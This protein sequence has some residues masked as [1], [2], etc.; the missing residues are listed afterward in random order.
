MNVLGFSAFVHDSAAA[1]VK[2]GQ[3]IAAAE[4]ERFNREKH[5]SH[6]PKQAIYYCLGEAGLD[7]N[8][9]DAIAFYFDLSPNFFKAAGSGLK[10]SLLWM[11]NH[12]VFL[13]NA[14]FQAKRNPST[15]FRN[16]NYL[17]SL[18]K[19]GEIV[20]RELMLKRQDRP[21]LIGVPHHLAHIGGSYQISGFEDAS[22]LIADQR[23]EWTTTTLAEGRDNQL[24]IFETIPLP[25]SLG[26]LYGAITAFLGFQALCDE[27]K[28]MGLSSYGQPRYRQAFNRFLDITPKGLFKLNLNYID[29]A[30]ANWMERYPKALIQELGLPR[31]SDSELDERHSDI[32]KSLQC[33]LEETLLSLCGYLEQRSSTDKLCLGGGIGLN[34][35]ANGRIVSAMPSWC[36]VYVPPAPGDA[37]AALGAAVRVASHANGNA[38]IELSTPYLGPAYSNEDCRKALDNAGFSFTQN[39]NVSETTAKLLNEGNIIGWYQGRMEF[40][41]RA[42]G[43]RSI[44]ADPRKVGTRDKVNILKGRE[45]WRPLAPSVLAHKANEWFVEPGESPYMSFTKTVRSEKVDQIAACVHVDGTARFQTVRR[46]SNPRY[47]KLLSDFERLTGVPCVLN[48]SFNCR[49]EPI[50]CTPQDAIKSFNKMGL[51]YLIMGD[52]VVAK[53]TKGGVDEYSKRKDS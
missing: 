33:R 34:S 38:R 47:W 27:G 22:I 53:R 1:V 43:N 24:N 12:T 29:F 41:P 9:L 21:T 51:D 17:S 36:Q 13:K 19:W 8:E 11:I 40:G 5:T 26:S 50:V 6:F 37:G 25:H 4:E 31:K 32:A 52:L 18:F 20:R 14:L 7:P 23:G 15:H 30:L 16:P 44:L 42:L 48:T 28:V 45:L 3:V 35:V 49:G 10:I 39:L 46:E 2:D